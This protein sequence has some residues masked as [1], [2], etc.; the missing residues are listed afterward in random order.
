MT[1]NQ[2]DSTYS[3]REIRF[4]ERQ[5]VWVFRN[6]IELKLGR[7]PVDYTDYTDLPSGKK[8]GVH[9]AYFC[10]PMRIAAEVEMR[11]ERAGSD[12]LLCVDY[13]TVGLSQECLAKCLNCSVEE[14]GKRIDR[15]LRYV[16]GWNRKERTYE[17]FVKHKRRR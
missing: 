15:A 3:Y 2:E 12:G 13:F 7:W 16:R 11:L 5:I 4:S 17:E 1:Y 8:K 10:A 14:I 6:L 9:E